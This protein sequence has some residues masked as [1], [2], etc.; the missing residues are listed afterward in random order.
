MKVGD[1]VRVRDAWERTVSGG[2][3]PR[4]TDDGWDGPMLLVEE[5]PPPDQGMFVAL[6]GGQCVVVNEK[7]GLTEVEV[8]SEPLVNDCLGKF[9][10][11]VGGK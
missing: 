5:Y 3:Q 1:L 2:F 6:W 11:A 9:S 4:I 7:E 8:I 10:S